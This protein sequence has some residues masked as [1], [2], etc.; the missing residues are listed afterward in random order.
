MAIRLCVLV[1]FSTFLIPFSNGFAQESQAPGM[2]SGELN[3]H[4]FPKREKSNHP[5]WS[6]VNTG[7]YTQHPEF[8]QLP[9]NAPCD[10][11][12]EDLSKRTA[13]ERYF[14]DQANPSKF[15]IQKS[16]GLLHQEI[17]GQFITINDRLSEKSEG[18]Y[19]ASNQIE[20]VGIQTA[21]RHSYIQTPFGSIEFNNWKLYGAQQGELTLLAKADWTNKTVGQDG[22]YVTEV[23]PGIDAQLIVFRGS[24]KTN[25]I[26]KHYSFGNFDRLVFSDQFSTSAQGE[27]A[28]I[29]SGNEVQVNLSNY[30]ALTVGEAIAYPVNEEK[31]TEIMLPYSLD[32]NTLQISVP[33]NWLKE[34]LQHAHVIIDPLVQGTATL[35]QASITGSMYNASCNFT[36]SC[37][38]NLTVAAPAN[39]TFTDIRWS[40]NYIAQGS[41]RLNDGAVKFGLGNCISP[42]QNTFFWFCNSNLS[43][44]CNGNNVSVFN[45]LGS[46]L[47]APSCSPQNVT[48]TMKFYRRCVGSTGCNNACIGANSPWT[49]VVEGRTIEYVAATNQISVSSTTV[50]AGQSITAS[51]STQ[52]GVPPYAYNWSFSPSGTPSVGTG[53][54]TSITFPTPGT[55]TLYSIVTDACGNQITVNRNITVTAAPVVTANPNPVTLCS[56]QTT[57]IGLTSSMNNTSYSW[58]VVQSGVTGA[59]NGSAAGGG[60]G[61]SPYTLNQTLTNNGTTPGTATYTITPTAGGCPGQPITVIVTVNPVNTT[62]AASSSPTVCVNTAISPVITHTTTG[63]TGI[64]TAT[65]LPAGVTASWAAN[66]ITISGTPT[67]TGTFN[68]TIPLTGGCGTVNATGTITVNPNNTVS[69]PSS[70][71]TLC[72]NT[73]ISPVITHTTTGATGIGTTTG[74]PAG[75]TANWSGNTITISGTPTA[76]GTFNYT[77]P[78]TGGCGT[79]NATGTIT[80]NPINTVGPASSSP[81]LCVN[82]AISP[83]ITHTTTG[84]TGIG[85]ATGLPAG[86]TASWAANTITISGTPTAPGTFNY[87]IPLTGGCG[88]V[89]ATGTITVISVNTVSAASSSPTVCVNTAISPVITHTTTGATGIG[90]ATGLPAGVTANWSGNTITISGTPTAA[91]T[92]NYTI[93]L[94]GGCGT[95]NATGTITVNP[96]NTVGPASSS[97]TLCVNTAISPVI[98]HSTTGATGIGTPTGLPA[99][100]TASWAANTITISGTPTARG[101][102]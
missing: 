1:L 50:C 48:F 49:M 96:I 29:P 10:N 53:A 92:F 23:F 3:F 30:H 72:V 32:H 83:V 45:D 69:A 42:A 22:M 66:T 51:T 88:T 4:T 82:T 12:V 7:I 37:D 89:N 65:G 5:L 62:S 34:E 100:V 58:T 64:G 70:T 77:I 90:T 75:V 78:L 85:T 91:G 43:G 13:V 25:F 56:G 47:P 86:V 44:T 52:Y 97:P 84:A 6:T 27:V 16:I 40:F 54:S 102:I 93:P 79:V 21:H 59:S 71:P 67:V 14:I 33:T 31:N 94:T 101:H 19:E 55:I 15:Y 68:Y 98:T 35:A 74:L 11:C 80:V 41:C 2:H 18:V 61:T 60:G 76:A 38:Y 81:T 95:V 9:Y 57:G 28:L 8:G 39:V 73:A 99:G 36:N 87:T 17:N 63:A 20:P 24:I 26:V 46:C